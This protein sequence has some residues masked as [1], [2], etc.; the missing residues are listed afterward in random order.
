MEKKKKEKGLPV[1]MLRGIAQGPYVPNIHVCVYTH[2]HI[3]IY[4]YVIRVYTATSTYSVG[5]IKQHVLKISV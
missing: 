2:T 1:T 3:Y 4:M 5:L